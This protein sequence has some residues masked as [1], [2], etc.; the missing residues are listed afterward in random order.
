MVQPGVKI[1]VYGKGG[2]A[3][4]RWRESAGFQG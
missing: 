1:S 4:I 2:E 3:E